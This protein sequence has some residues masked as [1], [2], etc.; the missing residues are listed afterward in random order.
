MSVTEEVNLNCV[1]RVKYR[2]E[3]NTDFHWRPMPIPW[4][5]NEAEI[6]IIAIL[7][8]KKYFWAIL[9]EEKILLHFRKKKINSTIHER[10]G[11]VSRGKCKI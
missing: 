8:G 2:S 7:G 6:F 9:G 11:D 10:L 5:G 3:L 1:R 4:G